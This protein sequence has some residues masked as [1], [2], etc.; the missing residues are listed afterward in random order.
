[1]DENG[2]ESR[3]AEGP[4]V[5]HARPEPPLVSTPRH[6][7]HVYGNDVDFQWTRSDTA[8]SYDV[9]IADEPTFAHPIAVL[10]GYAETHYDRTL[11]PGVHYWRVASRATAS[12]RGPFG[13][14]VSFTLRRYP[15]GREAQAEVGQRTL[16]L[17]WTAGR[18]GET[19]QF[20]LSRDRTFATHLLD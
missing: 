14:A 6:Q 15:E 16:T 10:T 7:S 13:D 20:E 5:I 8:T 11:A 9:E 3:D 1:I 19:A 4:L 17:R 2:L 12:N 18:P